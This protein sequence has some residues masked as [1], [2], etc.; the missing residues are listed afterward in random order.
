MT[1]RI[2]TMAFRSAA[3]DRDNQAGHPTRLL[4]VCGILLIGA[5]VAGIIFA[6]TNLRERSLAESERG[7]S[8][9][10]RILSDQVGRTFQ[11]ISNVQRAVLDDVRALGLSSRK[12]FKLA[13]STKK[14][15]DQIRHKAEALI[16]VNAISVVNTDG[17]LISTSV[18]W[19]V[20]AESFA[21]RAFFKAL[22]ST[23]DSQTFISLPVR[24]PGDDMWV[25]YV[26][27]KIAAA[28]G[29]LLGVLLS[30]VHL[31]YF[32]KIFA[33]VN[34]GND[35]W[36][37][38]SRDDGTVIARYPWNES[39]I[40]S[41]FTNHRTALA[42][43]DRG[44]IRYFG[45]MPG[46]HRILAADQ[47]P[48][49]PLIVAASQASGAV[50]GEEQV[51]LVIGVLAI[52]GITIILY[53]FYRQ[54]AQRDRQAAQRLETAINNMSQGL[55]LFDSEGRLVI[56]NKFYLD[57]YGLSPEI[58]KPG[59]TIRDLIGLR[60]GAGTLLGDIDE[61]CREL[62]QGMSLGKVDE[63][64]LQTEGG[65]SIRVVN[66]PLP[67]GGW[68]STH[69]DVSEKREIDQQRERDRAFLQQILDNVPIMIAVKDVKTRRFVLANRAAE[70]IW[71]IEPQSAIGKTD[72]E[73][74]SRAQADKILEVDNQAIATK[75]L[76]LEAHINLARADSPLTVTS[77]RV[78]IHGSDGEPQYLICVIED[79]TQ[80]KIVEQERD[81]NRKF[82][83]TI[84]D[85]VPVM[86]TVKDATTRRY[87]LANPAVKTIWNMSTSTFIGKTPEEIFPPE[88][89]SQFKANDE[90]ALQSTQPLILRVHIPLSR[91]RVMP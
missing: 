36:V 41:N 24:S 75:E 62:R 9:S 79:V 74:F 1:K 31:S 69:E 63:K 89:A 10:V 42:S 55:L 21:D 11:A 47:V 73:L 71:R 61:Y 17:K 66:L 3:L 38:L 8:N 87:L 43:S 52:L 22:R 81:E 46:N 37:S 68:V 45:K 91:R 20:P 5:V 26:A 25:V 15:H 53:L 78:V 4:I 82:L 44:T 90:S 33:A 76:F 70:P 16:Q 85:N 84:I 59:V 56:C 49:F 29:E 18:A 39:I 51:L 32:E 12:D 40:G 27:R 30:T 35:A 2:P 34:L 7:L 65:R 83:Q 77:R 86:I 80:Q 19:P 6:T 13:M 48:G 50:Q 67:D 72:Y 58:V 64:I 88:L 60:Q 28:N 14:M 57:M 54:I 23:Q